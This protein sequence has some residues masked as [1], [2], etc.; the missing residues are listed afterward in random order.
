[1]PNTVSMLFPVLLH[2]VFDVCI[3]LKLLQPE[4]RNGNN[5][6]DDINLFLVELVT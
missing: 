5:S 3:F 6:I 2:H 4:F 1:M